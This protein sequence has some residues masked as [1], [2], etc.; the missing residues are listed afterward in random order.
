VLV[1]VI[2]MVVVILGLA[3]QDEVPSIAV[4]IQEPIE[5]PLRP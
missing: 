3:G 5:V 1:L 4:P 2:V